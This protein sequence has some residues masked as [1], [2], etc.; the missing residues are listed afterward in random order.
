M[1]SHHGDPRGG[2]SSEKVVFNYTLIGDPMVGKKEKK[3]TKYR[4]ANEESEEGK[5]RDPAVQFVACGGF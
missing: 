4:Q 2:S 5:T 3:N 1:L